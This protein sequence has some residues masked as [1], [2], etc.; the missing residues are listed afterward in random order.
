MCVLNGCT[1]SGT[2][3]FSVIA[4]P[5][6]NACECCEENDKARNNGVSE[7]KLLPYSVRPRL[8]VPVYVYELELVLIFKQSPDIFEDA[9]AYIGQNGIN[10]KFAVSK[11][12]R[13]LNTRYKIMYVGVD[14]NPVDTV[15]SLM[16]NE[17]NLSPTPAEIHAKIVGN[18]TSSV[19]GNDTQAR[20]QSVVQKP[21]V[22][23]QPSGQSASPQ[24]SAV[25]S[26]RQGQP[27]VQTPVDNGQNVQ[28][29][30]VI[31]QEASAGNFV[32]TFGAHK[33]MT[34]R[35][36]YAATPDYLNFLRDNSS[37]LVEGKCVAFLK[38]IGA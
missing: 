19:R 15:V 16:P 35:E 20:Q 6:K 30:A 9:A 32:L 26:L 10:S 11:S 2:R 23:V 7:N 28:D 24:R 37:G 3:F 17:I 8:I 29:V 34:L 33:G 5:G 31:E 4:C 21:V 38:E 18:Q 13:G 36:I 22:Q 1:I 25:E 12:G 27:V 14:E